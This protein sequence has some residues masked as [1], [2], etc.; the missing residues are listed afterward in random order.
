MG[1][2]SGTLGTASVS[3]NSG[4][5][6]IAITVVVGVIG[7]LYVIAKVVPN[8]LALADTLPREIPKL[9]ADKLAYGLAARMLERGDR[10]SDDVMSVRAQEKFDDAK[11]ETIAGI[12]SFGGNF[13]TLESI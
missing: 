9:L 6:T 3:F 1:N 10:R 12:N 13:N 7:K 2:I 4:E 5:F 8:D 11:I